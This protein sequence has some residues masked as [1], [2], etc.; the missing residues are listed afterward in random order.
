MLTKIT[1]EAALNAELEITWVVNAMKKPATQI[2]VTDFPARQYQRLC[3]FSFALFIR[4][5][6]VPSASS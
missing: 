1:V 3:Q 2:T 6:V 4:S 5:F